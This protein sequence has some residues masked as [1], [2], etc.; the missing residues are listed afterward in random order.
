MVDYT[1]TQRYTT[2][3]THTVVHRYTTHTQAHPPTFDVELKLG[4][5]VTLLDLVEVRHLVAVLV[6]TPACKVLVVAPTTEESW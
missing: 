3:Y 2:N 4:V 1:H 6:H 5:L